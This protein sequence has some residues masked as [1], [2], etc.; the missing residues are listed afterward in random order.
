MKLKSETGT[1][2]LSKEHFKKLWR[3]LGKH[4]KWEKFGGIDKSEYPDKPFPQ[5]RQSGLLFL[6]KF[7]PW[8]LLFGFFYSFYWDFT[9][10]EI[11][12]LGNIYPVEG[13]LRIVS[14]SGLIGFLTNWLA[15]TMLFRPAKKRPL[16]GHGLIPAQK[17][18]IAFRLATTVSRDLINPD[19]IKKKIHESG[20]ISKYREMA[21]GYIK[22]VIDNPEFR[23]DLKQ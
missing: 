4:S 1:Q 18:R 21:S 5:K 12:L 14:V 6:L 23:A 9:G 20:V 7:I 3:L 13:L 22:A 10:Q 17:E 11:T 15:I 19:I 8:I 2:S 16:L